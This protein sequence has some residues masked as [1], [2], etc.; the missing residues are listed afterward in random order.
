MST[1]S[2]NTPPPSS[3]PV[4]VADGAPKEP[5]HYPSTELEWLVATSF[6]HAIE[7]YTRED[8]VKCRMWAEKAIS[9]AQW[10]EDGGVLCELLRKKY[11]GLVWK[12]DI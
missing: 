2:L 3:S 4:K 1:F 12:D 11:S 6:N 7:Y 10:A 5:G 8:D 9:L